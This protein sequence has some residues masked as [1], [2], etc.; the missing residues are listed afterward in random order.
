MED[1]LISGVALRRPTRRRSRSSDVPDRPGVA[2]A[3]FRAVADEGVNIDMIVQNVSHDG[4]DRLSFT[5][6]KAD[7]PRLKAVMERL[8]E[9]VGADGFS[10]G[11]RHRQGVAGRAP[12]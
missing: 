1:A 8:V 11:R 4:R 5:A 6:P 9:Q 12:A 10:D 3:I 2:A 7:L